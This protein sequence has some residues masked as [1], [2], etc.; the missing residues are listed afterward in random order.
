MFHQCIIVSF[1]SKKYF[2]RGGMARSEWTCSVRAVTDSPVADYSAPASIQRVAFPFALWSLFHRFFWLCRSPIL[3]DHSGVVANCDYTSGWVHWVRAC[4]GIAMWWVTLRKSLLAF[5]LPAHKMQFSLYLFYEI[6]SRWVTLGISLLAFLPPARKI[7]FSLYSVYSSLH[8][9]RSM[10]L[11]TMHCSLR[12]S[13]V[14][15]LVAISGMI[16]AQP[17][18]FPMLHTCKVTAAG[19]FPTCANFATGSKCKAVYPYMPAYESIWEDTVA[20]VDVVI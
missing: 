1:I 3:Y 12:P 7:P 18:I 13:P 6:V 9:A 14:L 11:L 17:T 2:R 15:Q 20:H 4:I 19:A 16:C 5:L 10:W 8:V